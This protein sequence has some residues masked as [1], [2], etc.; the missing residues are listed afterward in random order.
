[1]SMGEQITAEE[2]KQRFGVLVSHEAME[3]GEIRFRLLNGNGNGYVL[4]VAASQG[5]WQ[6]SHF[7]RNRS[8][9]YIVE[10]GWMALAVPVDDYKRL[11]ISIVRKG[12]LISTKQSL[13]HNIYLPSHAIL[14]TVKHGSEEKSA[15]WYGDQR[16]DEMTTE[17]SEAE[18][19]AISK[20]A[21]Q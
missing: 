8:E 5:A 9:T 2:A 15:D 18:M 11:D 4:T 14:H 16:L 21:S 7:H 13:S 1:M 19:L 17:L 10:R 20:T 6:R 12:Q 3:N